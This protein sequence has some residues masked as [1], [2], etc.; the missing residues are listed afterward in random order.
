MNPEAKC[1]ALLKH[2]TFTR[3]MNRSNLDTSPLLSSRP[4]W[5][6]TGDITEEQH[7]QKGQAGRKREHKGTQIINHVDHNPVKEG[8]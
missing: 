8:P 2:A 7:G 5:L 1:Q 3:A 6:L 4:G